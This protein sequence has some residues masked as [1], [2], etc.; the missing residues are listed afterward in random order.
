MLLF[1]HA[2]SYFARLRF[3]A[4]RCG[5]DYWP[6]VELSQ[7]S[8]ALETSMLRT[9]VLVPGGYSVTSAAA[10]EVISGTVD[11]YRPRY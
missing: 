2:L 10:D 5:G 3:C 9:G 11:V 7:L 8:V 1:L 4:G 6:C